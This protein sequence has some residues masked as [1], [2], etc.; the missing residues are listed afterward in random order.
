MNRDITPVL[1]VEFPACL[2]GVGDASR[3]YAAEIAVQKGKGWKEFSGMKLVRSTT[4]ELIFENNDDSIF[5]MQLARGDY[6]HDGFEDLLVAVT[7]SVRGHKNNTEY[8]TLSRIKKE[9]TILSV[10]HVDGQ[11]WCNDSPEK[12]ASECQKTCE[13]MK[14]KGEIKP[15]FSIEDCRKMLCSG[16]TMK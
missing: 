1:A 3:K 7:W 16:K 14:A 11:S 13:E 9:M 8:A 15:G 10:L 2:G 6:N 12:R 4:T 5:F